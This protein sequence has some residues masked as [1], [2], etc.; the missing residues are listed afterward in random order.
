ML[1]LMSSIREVTQTF[2]HN[3]ASLRTLGGAA[4]EPYPLHQLDV[5][6]QKEISG[7]VNGVSSVEGVFYI[8]TRDGL[9]FF[10]TYL[11]PPFRSSSFFNCLS[12]QNIKDV[13]QIAPGKI[14][15]IKGNMLEVH[16][17][18]ELSYNDPI[19]K[20]PQ[21]RRNGGN[22]KF[23]SACHMTYS[24][25]KEVYI[26]ADPEGLEYWDTT[27]RRWD[28]D[29]CISHLTEGQDDD[30]DDFETEFKICTYNDVIFFTLLDY[31]QVGAY[32]D[33]RGCMVWRNKTACQK[34]AGIAASP[35]KLYVCESQE[36]NASVFVFGHDGSIIC[37]LRAY[38]ITIPWSVAVSDVEL[39]VAEK[40][41]EDTCTKVIILKLE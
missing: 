3:I 30:S 41:R 19:F 37:R 31:G 6:T 18:E 12:A 17:R 9:Q 39:A 22:E 2:R 28:K 34:P 10:Y 33:A 29:L 16:R 27:A 15:I 4:A 5:I 21:N 25:M 23:F 13:C 14:L 35:T 40:G 7:Y 38:G 36:S 32:D 24:D 20:I 8:C 11:L 26:L 1:D